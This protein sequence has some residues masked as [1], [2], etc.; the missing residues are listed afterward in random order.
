MYSVFQPLFDSG[1]TQ[2]PHTPYVTI[3]H[4]VKRSEVIKI[5]YRILN[6]LNFK[7]MHYV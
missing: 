4:I 1:T 5:L 2:L 7:I 6:G 3:L